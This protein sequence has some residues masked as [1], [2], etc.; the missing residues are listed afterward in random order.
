MM[1]GSIPNNPERIYKILSR[2]IKQKEWTR[3]D[4]VSG[5]KVEETLN[6]L[7]SKDLTKHQIK[8]IDK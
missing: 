4:I 7:N 5:D 6:L 2:T 8:R 1:Q 3:M